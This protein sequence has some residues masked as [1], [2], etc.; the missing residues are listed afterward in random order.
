MWLLLLSCTPETPLPAVDSG[1]VALPSAEPVWEV[2]ALEQAAQ[3]LMAAPFPRLDHLD[4]DYLAL[5]AQG[6]S[7]C[8]GLGNNIKDNAVYGC[9]TDTGMY[10][11]GVS[12]YFDERR[13][14][15]PYRSLAGDFLITD[16]QGRTMD[17]GAG[18]E[19]YFVEGASQFRWLGSVIWAGRPA[20]EQGVS[21]AVDG[22]QDQGV[23]SVSGGMRLAQGT[24]EF[25]LARDAACPLSRGTLSMRGPDQRW[26]R[27]ALDCSGCGL[28]QFEGQEL[29]TACIDPTPL[30]DALE[31]PLMDTDWVSP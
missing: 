6:T 27:T 30:L 31:E 21:V 22:G 19:V 28:V 26:Y 18:W 9:Q 24:V 1:S 11:S 3:S 5:M 12:D 13:D 4:Q 29:G 7:D 16:T 20:T 2:A 15:V 25:S 10:F 14:G 17:W 23:F 8:P